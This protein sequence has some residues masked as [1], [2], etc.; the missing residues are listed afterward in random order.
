MEKKYGQTNLER[1]KAAEERRQERRKA[2]SSFFSKL[3]AGSKKHSAK[4][5]YDSAE[6]MSLA[7]AK[8]KD[9]TMPSASKGKTAPPSKPKKTVAQKRAERFD[10][11]KIKAAKKKEGMLSKLKSSKTLAEFAKK[12]RNK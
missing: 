8:K 3:M 1:F 11:T 4:R 9:L 5:K 7:R 2:G 10:P 6:G 12:V